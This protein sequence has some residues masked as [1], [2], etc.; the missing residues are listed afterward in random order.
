MVGK[1]GHRR[2]EGV[3]ALSPKKDRAWFVLDLDSGHGHL[4]GVEL[5]P[6]VAAEA[7]QFREARSCAHRRGSD[8]CHVMSSHGHS[9]DRTLHRQE[10][11]TRT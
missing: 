3:R 10:P 5:S 6:S 2:K 8:S 7:V 11:S 1:A 4:A 9:N